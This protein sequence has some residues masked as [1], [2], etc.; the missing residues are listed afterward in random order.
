MEP[1]VPAKLPLDCFDWTKFI[2][3]IGQANAELARYDGILQGIVNPQVLLSPLTMQE[4]VLSSKIEG[5]QTSLEEVLEYEA[6]QEAAPDRT[7]DIREVLNYRQ[8]MREAVKYLE[9]RPVC[10][11]L[12]KKIHRTLMEG[13]RGQGVGGRGKGAKGNCPT[14]WA[15]FRPVAVNIP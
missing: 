15:N 14:S 11:N 10:L 2:R 1:H 13:V 12:L 9:R 3:L 5:T 7:E 4:A 6:A 8:A